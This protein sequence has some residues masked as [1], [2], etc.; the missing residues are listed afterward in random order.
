[1]AIT[2]IVVES[3]RIAKTIMFAWIRIAW[4]VRLLAVTAS[5]TLLTFTLVTSIGINTTPMNTGIII[6]L[7]VA[8]VHVQ[9][10]VGSVESR[11]AHAPIPVSQGGAA[12]SIATRLAPTVIPLLT[13]RAFPASWTCTG[14]V[15]QRGEM[16]A[17]PIPARTCITYVVHSDLTQ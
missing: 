2:G 6:E 16:A 12:G 3:N 8:L 5:I 11:L 9:V 10:A 4:N 15:V 7:A 17:T 13:C 1:M 14:I